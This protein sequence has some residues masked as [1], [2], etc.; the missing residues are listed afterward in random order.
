MI[1]KTILKSCASE[2]GTEKHSGFEIEV[3]KYN[4][5]TYIR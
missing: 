2:D 3:E 5:V 1:K 4:I